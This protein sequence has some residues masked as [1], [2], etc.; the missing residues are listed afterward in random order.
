MVYSALLF[1]FPFFL[2]F[3]LSFFCY[4]KETVKIEYLDRY[5]YKIIY[6]GRSREKIDKVTLMDGYLSILWGCNCRSY[7]LSYLLYSD[8]MDMTW[9][10]IT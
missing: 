2:S 3:F 6:L 10:D 8:H 5:L 9:H 7:H 4:W 1:F